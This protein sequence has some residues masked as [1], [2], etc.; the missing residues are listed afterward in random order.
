MLELPSDLWLDQPDAH[1]RIEE[2]FAR[3]GISADEAAG[4]HLFA[5]DGY[6]K[7][8]L[9]LD[10]TFC[11]GFDDE[12][13]RLWSERPD[14]LAVS[15]VGPGGPVAFRD[16]D[17]P[18]RDPGYRI[19]DL[20]SH[21]A[22]A[23]DLYLHAKIFRM[24][25]LI[26]DAPAVSF[27]SLYFEYGSQQALHRDP[28]FVVTDPPSHLLASWVALEDISPESGPLAY[29]PKS[30]R[31][32]WFEFEEGSVVCAQKIGQGP[33][34]EFAASMRATMRERGL[35]V[36][37][38]TCARGDVFIWHAG[39]IHGGSPIDDRSR[40]RKSFVTHYSTAADKKTRTA[41]MRVRDGDDWRRE[42]RNTETVIERGHARGLD[43]PLRT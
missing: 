18:Y 3:G 33:R 10:Q 34:A 2:R 26:Y 16:F 37:P 9:D 11:A 17:G 12:V 4:L 22:H 36:M 31:L 15:P 29:V 28:M 39:L 38:F 40:T 14:D 23:L 30:H 21:S 8:A 25:E 41:S 5:D 32:P 7:F 42:L 6:L 1:D 43:N 20:H 19:P 27:Q 13:A 24:V 35:E